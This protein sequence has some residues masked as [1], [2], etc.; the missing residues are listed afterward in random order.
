[1]KK[2]LVSFVGSVFSILVPSLLFAWWAEPIHGDLTRIG[3]WAER[4]FGPNDEHPRI[5]VRRNSAD[6][7]GAS[8]VVLG[9]SFSVANLW[10]SVLSDA[11][12]RTVKSFHYDKNCTDNWIRWAVSQ[13]T[14]ELVL[15]EV[16]ER[17]LV[18]R[19]SNLASCPD[20]KVTSVEVG[21][22]V[23]RN[24]RTSWPPTLDMTYLLTTAVNTLTGNFSNQSISNKYGVVNVRL[25][26]GCAR[27][28]NRKSENLLYLADDD[29][30]FEW[31]ER[32]IQNAVANIRRVQL[33]VEKSGKQ[34]MLLVVPDK[35]SVYRSCMLTGDLNQTSSLT[36]K[37]FVASGINWIDLQTVMGEHIGKVVDLY[38]PNNTHWSENGYILAGNTIAERVS[39]LTRS[40][41][42]TKLAGVN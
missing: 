32:H 40:Q 34:F 18:W 3:R 13:A 33:E 12:G 39:D 24:T 4:D 42:R 20:S 10:Q 8:I 23:Y 35:S 7:G 30:K 27:F 16:V 31:S 19:F 25:R 14:T 21:Q 28:S 36:Q 41:N 17:S 37:M 38:D 1:L 26:S 22:G 5:N 15:L 2:Y 11:S 29:F 6:V 9:D